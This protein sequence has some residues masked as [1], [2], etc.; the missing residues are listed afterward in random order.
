MKKLFTLV[1]S[2]LTFQS[3]AQIPAGDMEDWHTYT[4]DGNTLEAPDGWVGSDSAIFAFNE[5]FPFLGLTP[6]QQVFESGTAHQ[7]NAA[8]RLQTADIG[9]FIGLVGGTISNAQISF[10]QN[11]ITYNGGI[12][13]NERVTFVNAWLRYAPGIGDDSAS[14]VVTAL[15]TGS[16]GDSI[17]GT[18]TQL[19]GSTNAQYEYH[20]AFVNYS[21][22][23]VVPE[24]I[25]ITFSSSGGSTPEEGSTL[26]VDDIQMS[27]LSVKNSQKV[28]AVKCYPNPSSGLVSVFNTLNEESTIKAFNINGQEVAVKQFKGNSS[29]DL[30]AQPSGVYFY[31]IINK[32]GKNIQHGKLTIVK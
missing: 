24:K 15:V 27:T 2:L 23:T 19:I 28:N 12:A 9:S 14:I 30:T 22:G 4:V 29:L 11:G 3:F 25:Q 21:D 17:V 26:R 18:G 10:D 7:G 8:A 6:A 5:Q 1:L 31:S 20:G 13:V 16:N 32:D